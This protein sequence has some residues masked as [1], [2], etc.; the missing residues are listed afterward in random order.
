MGGAMARPARSG[1][2]AALLDA[3]RD[4]FSRHGL[5]RARVEDIARRAG[6]SKGAFYLHFR[7]KED[8]FREIVQRF[9]GALEDHALRR[10]EVEDRI[11]HAEAGRTDAEALSRRIE[12]EC[13]IDADLLEL[14]W[15][16]RQILSALDGAAGKLYR[17]LLG[18]FR[19]RMRAL[20]AGRMAN[21]LCAGFRLR[22]DVDPDV[23]AD[24]VIGTYEDF[25]R[26]MTEMQD[27]P[28]LAAWARSL[29]LIL[30]QGILDRPAAARTAHRRAVHR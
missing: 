11:A 20:V 30:Y 28:D 24:I 13:A 18:D 5:G 1:A 7:T 12:A 6:I 17:D 23:I 8:A 9:L 4:E 27:K 15:R 2:H 16:N 14:F 3:A 22:R 25:A 26:R 21:G 19:R 10:D 29:L